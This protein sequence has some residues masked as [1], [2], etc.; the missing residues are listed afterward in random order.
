MLL[1]KILILVWTLRLV[2]LHTGFSMAKVRL[3]LLIL[4]VLHTGFSM[5]KVRLALLILVLIS[6][7]LW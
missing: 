5:A 2:V 4:V 6:L 3:A 7:S 1:L